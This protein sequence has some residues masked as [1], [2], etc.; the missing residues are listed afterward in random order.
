MHLGLCVRIRDESVESVFFLALRVPTLNKVYGMQC[1][2][3]F[4][5]SALF[6]CKSG[7]LGCFDH[8][9]G[10]RAAGFR[11]EE[12]QEGRERTCS[13]DVQFFGEL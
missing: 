3:C 8:C 5:F 4:N 2:E 9:L 10:K 11:P 7:Y 1:I 12:S 6:S 13:H